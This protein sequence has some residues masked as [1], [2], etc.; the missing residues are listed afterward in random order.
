M[1]IFEVQLQEIVSAS[2]I[3][4]DGDFFQKKKIRE[5]ENIFVC[6]EKGRAPRRSREGKNMRISN[7]IS[8]WRL[9]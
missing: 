9:S 3:C 1:S 8:L 4:R 6:E 5:T 7:E 2:E